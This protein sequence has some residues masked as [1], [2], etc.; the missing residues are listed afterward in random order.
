M[1]VKIHKNG[2]AC[3]NHV[4]HQYE[5]NVYVK[6]RLTVP[7]LKNWLLLFSYMDLEIFYMQINIFK[8]VPT[9]EK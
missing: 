4:Q 1:F 9:K 6:Y 3:N 7:T 5:E 8:I 2:Q